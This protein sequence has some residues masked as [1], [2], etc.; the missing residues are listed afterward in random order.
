MASL[1]V[2]SGSDRSMVRE[3]SASSNLSFSFQNTSPEHTEGSVVRLVREMLH[4]EEQ[5]NEGEMHY[6]K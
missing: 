3:N 2:G 4:D 5:L 6:P 1:I